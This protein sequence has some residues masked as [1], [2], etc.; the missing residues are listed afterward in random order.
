MCLA[1]RSE[2]S[3]LR[4][5]LDE[6]RLEAEEETRRVV[7]MHAEAAAEELAAARTG[8][9]VARAAAEAECVAYQAPVSIVSI[10][11]V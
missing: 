4:A 11:G 8:S 9:D 1:L 7:A 3:D 6:Q 5:R 2:A 10:A